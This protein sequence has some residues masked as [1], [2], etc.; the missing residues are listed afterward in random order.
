MTRGR[1]IR[2]VPS[3]ST[4]VCASG[5]KQSPIDILAPSK[6]KRADLIL[7]DFWF[8]THDFRITNSHGHTRTRHN[9]VFG[10]HVNGRQ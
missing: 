2:N 8:H 6:P 3:F 10:R 7:N 5:K 9:Y 4:G 1:G